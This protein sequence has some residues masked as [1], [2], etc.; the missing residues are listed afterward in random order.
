MLLFFAQ[1]KE[2]KKTLLEC[3]KGKR[4][5]VVDGHSLLPGRRI[6][7]GVSLLPE[8]G[9]VR[10]ICS[11]RRPRTLS[12][13]WGTGRSPSPVV[14]GYSL[15]PGRGLALGVSLLPERGQVRSICSRRCPQPEWRKRSPQ[16]YLPL[17]ASPF[18]KG[19]FFYASSCLRV[20]IPSSVGLCVPRVYL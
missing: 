14:D 9:Q 5:P 11:R 8:R 6:A 17:G 18:R 3:V 1:T 16:R 10:S 19:A 2:K 12:Y 4:I 13:R 15:L 20:L 7:L